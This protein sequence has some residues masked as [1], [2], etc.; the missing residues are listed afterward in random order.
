MKRIGLVCGL[1]CWIAFS[2][3]NKVAAQ[4]QSGMI[5]E[6]Q[7]FRMEILTQQKDVVW[8]FDFL[9]DGKIIFTERQGA[10]KIFDPKTKK[11]SDVAG[12]PAVY[13]KGQGGLLDIRVHPT[14]KNQIFLTY[15]EPMD[16]KATTA[17]ASAILSG[18]KLTQFKKLFSAIDPNDNEI[19]FGSRIEFDGEGHVFV[20]A[21]ER[22]K[23]DQAQE[24]KNHFGK[25]LRLNEDGTI[26][27][28]NPFAKLKTAKPEIWSFGHRNPQGLVRNPL[29]GDLW[30]AEMG[31]KGG[32]ELN[33]IR[34]GL[35]YGWP[36]VTFGREYSGP[37][38]GEGTS[39]PGI[40]NPVVYWVP[41][42]SPSGMTIYHGDVFPK[43]K[44]NIFIGALSGQH[45]RRLILDGQKVI[46]Q[47]ELLM[48]Q[49]MRIRHV[50]T[51]PD[52]FLY[53]ST[54]DGRIARLV[55]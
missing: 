41:S 18:T 48:Y 42:I 40:E 8:G 37:K 16:K 31:P 38:I 19:H 13:A 20:T 54:D 2:A 10:L 9:S 35:N 1:I 17:L 12:A 52:G 36:V 22:N 7:E 23:R 34:P 28:D 4:P 27:K 6:G 21:G 25:V 49:G 47:E 11:V 51:G 3:I 26:P 33:L 15:A 50:R 29:T 39:K 44:G 32:D 5:S 55:R 53:L 14:N 43:W 45:L 46:K 30:L 24:L